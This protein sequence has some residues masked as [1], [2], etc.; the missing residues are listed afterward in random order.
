M[1][2]LKLLDTIKN[3]LSYDSFKMIKDDFLQ[4]NATNYKNISVCTSKREKAIQN[5]IKNATYKDDKTAT[6]T[7]GHT[8]LLLD[9]EPENIKELKTCDLAK[10]FLEI[11]KNRKPASYDYIAD[12]VS[13][14]KTLKKQ[15]EKEDYFLK[16]GDHLYNMQ[17]ISKMFECIADSK[18]K[19][20]RVEIGEKGELLM[21]QKYA[22]VV[23]P[24]VGDTCYI[25]KNCNFQD[26]LKFFDSI[27]N[28]KI[29]DICKSA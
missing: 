24:V 18:E 11:A 8:M 29:N 23:L 16:I 19:H 20:F 2:T 17:L 28:E 9:K 6:W 3:E 22:A 5:Y 10:F 15:D 25:A 1:N 7:D 26:I 21:S 4:Q 14:Y 27:E 12:S 13:V